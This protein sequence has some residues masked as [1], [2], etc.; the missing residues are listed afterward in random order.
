[1]YVYFFPQVYEYWNVSI[2]TSLFHSFFLP[3]PQYSSLFLF[4]LLSSYF[5]VSSSKVFIHWFKTEFLNSIL[6]VTSVFKSM[7]SY[8]N[9]KILQFWKFLFFQYKLGH[10]LNWVFLVLVKLHLLIMLI[11][12]LFLSLYESLPH[13]IILKLWKTQNCQ[14]SQ[15][16]YLNYNI[17]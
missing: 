9:D 5:N 11:G 17:M 8:F 7:M 13:T 6:R 16:N 2:C 15:C 14:Y 10:D 3:F 4:L 12:A 1:M